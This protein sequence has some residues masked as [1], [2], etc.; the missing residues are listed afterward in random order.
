MCQWCQQSSVEQDINAQHGL[1]SIKWG[2]FLIRV[3]WMWFGQIS[4]KRT[5][6][7][8]KW[9][10]ICLDLRTFVLLVCGLP[11]FWDVLDG[12]GFVFLFHGLGDPLCLGL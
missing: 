4:V 2:K 11:K 1:K 9:H 12:G 10:Q 7:L 6:R 5:A 3:R 8:V